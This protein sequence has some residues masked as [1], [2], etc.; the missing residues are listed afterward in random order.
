MTLVATLVGL[1]V[2]ALGFLGIAAPGALLGAVAAVQAPPGIYLAA[3]LR[4]GIGVVLY[5]AAPRSRTPGILR[6]L[7]VVVVLGGLATPFV[8][9]GIAH[10]FLDR[11]AAGG[12]GFMRLWAGVAV[13][14]G[15]FI[16][17]AVVPKRGAPEAGGSGR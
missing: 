16:L 1:L 13:A 17:Y 4:I 5:R 10:A 12:P 14:V 2:V 9:P 3:L 11:W 7:G 15:A 8:G 6:V